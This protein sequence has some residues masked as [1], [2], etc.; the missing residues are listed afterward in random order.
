MSIAAATAVSSVR[1][2]AAN[3]HHV[4]A[5]VDSTHHD[6]DRPTRSRKPADRL[7]DLKRTDLALVSFEPQRIGL[8][9]ADGQMILDVVLISKLVDIHGGALRK[10]V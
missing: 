3:F 7:P 9:P 1:V 4:P 6:A 5:S 10:L 2:D 8:N